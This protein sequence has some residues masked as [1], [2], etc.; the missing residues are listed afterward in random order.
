MSAQL[1]SL[2]ICISLDYLM[3]LQDFFISGLPTGGENNQIRSRA[4]STTNDKQTTVD[5]LDKN[6]LQ[7]EQRIQR[8]SISVRKS[9]TPKRISSSINFAHI[10][11]FVVFLAPST[12]QSS[13]PPDP[14]VE[15]HIDIIVKNPE[16]ILLEDQHKSNSNC[17][18]L[19]VS[20]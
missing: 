10:K 19:D 6:Q 17:L 11:I 4:T 16:V 13:S 12:P 1:E 8:P 7:I 18:V 14:D 5:Q 2:Y 9:S 20:F 3:T 15:T